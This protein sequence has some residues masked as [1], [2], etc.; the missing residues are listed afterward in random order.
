MYIVSPTPITFNITR[1][2]NAAP[3]T[4]AAVRVVDPSKDVSFITSFI[5]N[6]AP[7]ALLTKVFSFS[8]TP[9]EA[10]LYRYEIL[11]TNTST[12]KIMYSFSINVIAPSNT[13]AT[14]ITV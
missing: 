7:T 13:F 6:D 12:D 9:S 11:D 14:Q 4:I 10:G 2:K 8:H 3:S 5:S 1:A